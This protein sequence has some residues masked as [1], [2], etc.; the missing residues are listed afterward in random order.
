MQNAKLKQ[1]IN[2]I[3]AFLKSS[4]IDRKEGIKWPEAN[5]RPNKQW[6][7]IL[8]FRSAILILVMLFFADIS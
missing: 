7:T 2:F 6:A 4:M 1:E 8:A 3:K 5:P